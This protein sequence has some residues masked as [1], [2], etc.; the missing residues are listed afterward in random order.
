M[1]EEEEYRKSRNEVESCM[2]RPGKSREMDGG[3]VKSNSVLGSGWNGLALGIV[4]TLWPDEGV[5]QWNAVG[6]EV[7]DINKVGDKLFWEI[8]LARGYP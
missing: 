4:S 2:R 6:K 8:C 1:T 7:E 3:G 5:E